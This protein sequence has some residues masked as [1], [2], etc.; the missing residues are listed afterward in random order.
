MSTKDELNFQEDHGVAVQRGRKVE[1]GFK[2]RGHAHV[3]FFCKG[4]VVPWHVEDHDNLVVNVGKNM[5]L[6]VQFHGDTPSTTWYIGLVNNT[7]FSAFAAGDTM[8]SHT[9]W[10]ESAAYSESVRQTWTVGASSGQAITN[11]TAA[12]F[13]CNTDSTVLKG[14]FITDVSTKSGTTGNLWAATAFSANVTCNNGDTI[15]VTYTV[16]C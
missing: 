14:I 15:K 16:S 12:T 10:L 2:F 11:G 6:G 7:S 1:E 5:V 13:T 8:A 4:E 3:E 9:G